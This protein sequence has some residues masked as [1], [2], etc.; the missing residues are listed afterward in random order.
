MIGREQAFVLVVALIVGGCGGEARRWAGPPP[1][2]A[3]G[4]VDVSGFDEAARSPI[5][6]AAAFLRLDERQAATTALVSRTGP[7]G[8]DSAA[9]TAT[10]DGL[11]DDSIRS[12][13][14]VLVLAKQQDGTWRLESAV[15]SQRCRQGRGHPEYSAAPCV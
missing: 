2:A 9:V 7:E 10:L 4:T 15:F 11:L 3:D 12:D 1:S 13:R 6:T 14:Y 8:G 5:E